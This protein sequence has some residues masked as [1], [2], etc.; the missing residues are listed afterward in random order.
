MHFMFKVLLYNVMYIFKVDYS[1]IDSSRS[2]LH[3]CVLRSFVR[4]ESLF[5]IKTYLWLCNICRH[6]SLL[7][8]EHCSECSVYNLSFHLRLDISFIIFVHFT[9]LRL[10]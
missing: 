6:D 10:F 5:T 2:C 3:Q 8:R 7:C 4:R 1:F 9:A